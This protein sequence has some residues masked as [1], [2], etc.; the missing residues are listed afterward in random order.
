[1][2]ILIGLRRYQGI[3]GGNS[4]EIMLLRLKSRLIDF[5]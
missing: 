1:M 3:I 2:D 4:Y 5:E